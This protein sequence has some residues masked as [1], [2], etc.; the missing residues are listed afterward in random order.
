[1]GEGKAKLSPFSRRGSQQPQQVHSPDGQWPPSVS[2]LPPL[3]SQ[4]VWPSLSASLL[5][6]TPTSGHYFG[7]GIN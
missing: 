2:P 3:G 5:A 4:S 6:P 7:A 1:M